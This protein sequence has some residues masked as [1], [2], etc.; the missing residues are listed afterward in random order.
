[1]PKCC[2]FYLNN[3]TM[4]VCP[5]MVGHTFKKGSTQ[6]LSFKY[7]QFLV[8]QTPSEISII[9]VI[10]VRCAALIKIT[11]KNAKWLPCFW[12]FNSKF[13]MSRF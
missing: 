7:H 8:F 6:N 12:N 2:D 1:M 9:K 10:S 5:K 11:Q 3:E 4:I 13:E